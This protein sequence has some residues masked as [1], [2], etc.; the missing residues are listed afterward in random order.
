MYC[1]LFVVQI[2]KWRLTT[3]S[4][5]GTSIK[6]C[7]VFSFYL[8]LSNFFLSRQHI[9]IIIH[10]QQKRTKRTIQVDEIKIYQGDIILSAAFVEIHQS[11]DL[12]VLYS[13]GLC[14][15]F[16]IVFFSVGI[17]CWYFRF[18]LFC[19]RRTVPCIKKKMWF[20]CMSSEMLWIFW[21][22]FFFFFFWSVSRTFQ[23]N[24]AKKR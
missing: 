20:E 9:V 17:H 14:H 10:S 6:L 3:K 5:T 18:I 22:L 13:F 21:W 23:T 16:W 24:Y 7:R 4:N 1:Q 12:V 11:V 19:H 8:K 15:S 2:Q